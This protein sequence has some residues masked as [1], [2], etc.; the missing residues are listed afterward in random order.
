M[1]LQVAIIYLLVFCSKIMLFQKVSLPV[2]FSLF[3]LAPSAILYVICTKVYCVSCM[4]FAALM[5][6]SF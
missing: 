2:H 3:L 1:C 4:Y 6:A 5:Q